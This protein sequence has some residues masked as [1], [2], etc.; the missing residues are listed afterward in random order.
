MKTTPGSG[1]PEASTEPRFNIEFSERIDPAEFA[2]DLSITPDV[3]VPVER[4][5]Y[6]WSEDG[7]QVEIFIPMEKGLEPEEDFALR[8]GASSVEDLV[9]NRM[10]KSLQI[11]FTTAQR[12]YEDID[13]ESMNPLAQAWLYIIWNRVHHCATAIRGY[14]S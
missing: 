8:I 3:G 13:P 12:P 5:I 14:R 1:E 7:K 11:E 9:G 4:W 10:E 2:Q 6:T